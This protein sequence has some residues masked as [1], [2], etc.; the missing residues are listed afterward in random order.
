MNADG[1]P[2]TATVVV[3]FSLGCRVAVGALKLLLEREDA[4][5]V[6]RAVLVAGA[7][8]AQEASAIAARVRTVNIH[9]PVDT[10]L[11]GLYRAVGGTGTPAGIAG[12]EHAVNL[13]VF[14]MHTMYSA[15]VLTIINAALGAFDADLPSLPEP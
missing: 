3:A 7:V 5:P 14:S 2:L 13:R 15:H 10:V 12:I 1:I 4:P 6:E 8:D 9:S 11:A